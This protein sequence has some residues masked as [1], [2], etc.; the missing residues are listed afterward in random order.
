MAE[1][2][3]ELQERTWYKSICVEPGC[4]YVGEGAVQGHCFHVVPDDVDRLIAHMEKAAEDELAFYKAEHPDPAKY[5]EVLESMFLC[6]TINWRS[7]LHEVIK[8]RAENRKLR[9]GPPDD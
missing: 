7:T 4:E 5:L 1:H 8:L 2:R 9:P 3:T 6:V